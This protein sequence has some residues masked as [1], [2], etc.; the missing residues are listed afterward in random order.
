MNLAFKALTADIITGYCFGKSTGYV[1]REDY[2]RVY[3]EAIDSVT[4]YV[5]WVVHVGWLGWLA[6]S[7]PLELFIRWMPAIAYLLKLRL[8]DSSSQTLAKEFD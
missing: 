1:D 5:H 6:E 2:N 3:F 4:E 7:L 8:V